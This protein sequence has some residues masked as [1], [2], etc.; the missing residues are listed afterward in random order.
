MTCP[1]ERYAYN[2]FLGF[3]VDILHPLRKLMP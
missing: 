2:D 1:L 3:L